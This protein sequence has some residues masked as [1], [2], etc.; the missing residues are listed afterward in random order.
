MW[1]GWIPIIFILQIYQIE[2]CWHQIQ[3]KQEFFT[4]LASDH[5]GDQT[6]FHRLFAG[7]EN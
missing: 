2:R 5:I 3:A 4:G 6:V 1:F 7:V